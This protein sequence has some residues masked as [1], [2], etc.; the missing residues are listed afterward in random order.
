[1]RGKKAGQERLPASA[2]GG[3][4]QASG[5][6]LRGGQGGQGCTGQAVGAG[7]GLPRGSLSAERRSGMKT[8]PAVVLRWAEM[9]WPF[10]SCFC[11][12]LGVGCPGRGCRPQGVTAGGWLRWA[13][14]AAGIASPF[15]KGVWAA[16]LRGHHSVCRTGVVDGVGSPGHGGQGQSTG[17]RSTSDTGRGHLCLMRGRRR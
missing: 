12:S 4:G 9:A 5:L 14:P 8:A 7:A 11:Q 10:R 15:L 13:V 1:M 16:H 6:L 17:E 2:V 3:V